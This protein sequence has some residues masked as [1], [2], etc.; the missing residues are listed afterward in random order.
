MIAHKPIQLYKRCSASVASPPG[1]AHFMLSDLLVASAWICS[2]VVGLSA[3]SSVV[4]LILRTSLHAG[5]KAL[6]FVGVVTAWGLM[7]ALALLLAFR[8]VYCESCSDRPVTSA[9]IHAF[10][11]LITPTLAL[12]GISAI[13]RRRSQPVCRGD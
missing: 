8:L 6:A 10:M 7:Q 1:F 4:D 3:F 2:A 5:Y 9:A 13:I 12:W 11:V